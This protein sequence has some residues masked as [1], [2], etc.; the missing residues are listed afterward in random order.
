MYHIHL[1]DPWW[2]RSHTLQNLRSDALQYPIPCKDSFVLHVLWMPFKAY[3]SPGGSLLE[4]TLPSSAVSSQALCQC[5]PHLTFCLWTLASVRLLC[6]L[7]SDMRVEHFSSNLQVLSKGEGRG[8][9]GQ[10]TRTV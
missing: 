1:L 10:K 8:T 5:F 7:T 9:G 3:L 2:D 4:P 6:F